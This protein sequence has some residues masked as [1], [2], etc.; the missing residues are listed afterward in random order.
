LAR[1]RQYP[2]LSESVVVLRSLHQKFVQLFLRN[3]RLNQMVK[4]E[5][6]QPWFANLRT[7]LEN[8]YLAHDEPWRQSGMSGPAERWTI[9]RKPIA[10][11]IDRSGSLLDIGCANG[12]LLQCCLAWT[13]ERGLQ[14]DPY[15]VDISPQLL[16]LARQRLPQYADHFFVGN[17]LDWIPPRKFDFVRTNL[18]YVPAN[19]EKAYLDHLFQ[20]HLRPGGRLLVANYAEDDP[21]PARGLLP[22]S[23]ATNQILAHLDELGFAAVGRRDGLDP[24]GRGN[25]RVAILPLLAFS[26]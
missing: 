22:G 19:Y 8:A 6:L 11:C 24:R 4:P 15:G 20:H 21:N 18:E 25:T 23:H 2:L 5:D 7:V 17:A 13:T 14:L 1:Q 9:L 16:D 10:D 26:L 12:Y 3:S